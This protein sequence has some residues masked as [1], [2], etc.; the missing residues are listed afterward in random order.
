MAQVGDGG[1]R[2]RQILEERHAVEGDGGDQIDPPNLGNPAAAEVDGARRQARSL[3][4]NAFGMK[5]T[6]G[7]RA[8]VVLRGGWKPSRL[9]PLLQPD[10]R[11]GGICWHGGYPHARADSVCATAPLYDAVFCWNKIRFIVFQPVRLLCYNAWCDADV[12]S[13]FPTQ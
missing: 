7:E 1:A 12:S 10:P 4:E 13:A 3:L 2:Q 5:A 8:A 6:R 11:V 9:A